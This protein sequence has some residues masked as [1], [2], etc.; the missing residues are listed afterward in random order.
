MIV[1]LNAI[2]GFYHEYRAD[3]VMQALKRM[4]AT[5]AKMLRNQQMTTLP[6]TKLV[7]GDVVLLETGNAV[8]ADVRLMESIHLK[9]EEAALTGESQ[10]IHAADLKIRGH[11]F[12]PQR[13]I[14][15]SIL[16]PYGYCQT[17]AQHPAFHFL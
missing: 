12:I 15:H 1:L 9:T 2:L 3:K 11:T 7:P 10:P 6:A 8:P 16:S 13:I 4:S 17:E 5:Q 14:F